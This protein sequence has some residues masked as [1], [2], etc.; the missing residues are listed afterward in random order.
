MLLSGG[1]ASVPQSK[2]GFYFF[3]SLFSWNR[4]ISTHESTAAIGA[5]GVPLPRDLRAPFFLE[6]ET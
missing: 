6:Y 4:E 5:S 2:D 1:P 3:R